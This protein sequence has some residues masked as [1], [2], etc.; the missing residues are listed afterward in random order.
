MVI[1]F[2]RE[3]KHGASRIQLWMREDRLRL[4]AITAFE[5]RLGAE[6]F[7]RESSI[8]TLLARR[9]L[10]LDALAGLLAGEIFSAL[11]MQGLGIGLRDSLLAG[12]CR[13]FDLQLATR[14][15]R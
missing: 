4:T 3:A 15:V 2:L 13:R 10:P 12:I 5:L 6:F 1:D 8:E 11:A 7:A 9:T 14:N